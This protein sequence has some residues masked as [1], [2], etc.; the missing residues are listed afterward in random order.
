MYQVE[1]I[2]YDFIPRVYDRSLVD[3]WMKIGEDEAF[4]YARR[5]IEEEGFLCGGSSGTAMAAAM[6]YIKKHDLGAD[7]RCVI[8]CP[9]NIRNYFTKFINNEWIYEHGLISEQ[10]FMEANIP[11][12]VPHNVWV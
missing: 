4:S 5:L 12:L 8:V 2:V 6:K 3:E 7:K 10:E 9:V 11:K 1:G